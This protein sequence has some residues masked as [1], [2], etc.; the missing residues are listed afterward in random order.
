MAYNQDFY[1]MYAEYL[2]EDP[3][4]ASHNLV[5]E[6]FQ[7]LAKGDL[8]VLD[9]GCGLGEFWQY[10]APVKY[11]GVDVNDVSELGG[12]FKLIQ[13][14]YHDL[15][16]VSQRLRRRFARPY[17]PNAF[18][19]L[20]SVECFHPAAERYEFY[21]NVFRIFPTIEFG[22]V[23]GF[24]YESRRSEEKVGETGGITSYQTIEDQWLY[25]SSAFTELRMHVR[26]PSKM[27]GQDVIEVW[28]FFTRR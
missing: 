8:Q 23:S 1:K 10:G 7:R 11:V 22:L 13:A 15:Q 2:Q 3:V 21:G 27:F 6:Q 16:G 25:T 17:L 24:F 19:S 20:F 14:D 9:L 5:F 4:R 28:K 12:D 18:V 26:T